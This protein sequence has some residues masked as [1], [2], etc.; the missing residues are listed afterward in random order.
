MS[1]AASP[2]QPPKMGA[3]YPDAD[4]IPAATVIIFR[5][6]PQ[7]GPPQLL[8]AQRGD[9]MRF[10]GGATVFP[11]GRIDH[12]D[13]E[14]ARTLTSS[15]GID[16]PESADKAREDTAAR[17]AGIRETLEE[18]GLAIG[19]SHK[20]SAE[21]AAQGRRLL[22]EEGRLAPVLTTLG[23]RLAPDLLVPFARWCPR[24]D[25]TFDT[26]FYLTD[27]GSG[28][29]DISVDGTEATRQ[30]W[31]SAADAL[32]KANTGEL[33]IIFPTAM[34][35]ER[36]AQFDNFTEARAHAETTPIGIITARIEEREGEQWLTI[37]DGLGYPVQGQPLAVAK[38][39]WSATKGAPA[40]A[41]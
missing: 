25:K 4:T 16:A 26:R 35:L 23:W 15:P 28:L 36:L 34:N 30:F 29:V 24:R 19:L 3:P 21:E 12:A 14:L 6:A 37:P 38:R 18:T 8:M 9:A 22:L 10:A 17:I 27:L 32:A 13:L 11:G 39:G 5:R 40:P 31:I 7:G 33:S 41:R 20:V 2:P 1:Q